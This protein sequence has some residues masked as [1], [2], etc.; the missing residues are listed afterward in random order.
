MKTISSINVHPLQGYL[1]IS[2]YYDAQHSFIYRSL[3]DG[4]NL[5]IFLTLQYPVLSM[6]IDYR[7]PRLYVMLS[8]GEIE[9]YSIDISQPWKTSVYHFGIDLRPYSID[10]HDDILGVMVFNTTDSIYDEISVDKFGR[11]VTEKSR[12]L[13]TPMIVRYIHEFKYPN[14]GTSDSKYLYL[15]FMIKLYWIFSG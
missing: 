14:I 1:Y 11:I 15:C 13:K 9:S 8:N 6:T 12:K 3:L 5:E 2:S 7:H 4:S 10:L